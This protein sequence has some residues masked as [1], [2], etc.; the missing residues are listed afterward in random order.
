MTVVCLAALFERT[1]Q[2]VIFVS[3]AIE[4]QSAMLDDGA[5]TADENQS[6]RYY[7]R[8]SLCAGTT[9][10]NIAKTP[11]LPLLSSRW[12]ASRHV[13][14]TISSGEYPRKTS[15]RSSRHWSSCA[16]R[17]WQPKRPIAKTSPLCRRCSTC[18]SLCP[19]RQNRTRRCRI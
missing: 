17:S 18:R 3:H 13:T 5:E 16:S 1:S 12:H 10:P 14:S 2:P 19:G 15:L 11:P 4:L 9:T 8:R 6:G 7:M